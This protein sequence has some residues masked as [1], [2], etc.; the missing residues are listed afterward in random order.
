[1]G[2]STQLSSLE[3]AVESGET[4]GACD[5]GFACAYT[6]TISWLGPATPLPTENNPR[7]VFER[8]FGDT[9]STDPKARLARL[10]QDRS[11]L[12][13]VREEAGRLQGALG[14]GDRAKLVESLD[15]IRDVG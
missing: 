8:M 11:V 12:D 1:M 6:N 15:A 7:T 2:A 9:G 10:R 5:V 14:Q 13:S 3:L 4:A